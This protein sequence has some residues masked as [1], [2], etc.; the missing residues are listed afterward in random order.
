MA[1]K[2]FLSY[3]REDAAG[4]ALA[5]FD[6]LEQSFPAESLFMDVEG[7]IGRGRTLCGSLRSRSALVM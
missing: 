5:L 6:R 2:I 1:G 4:F 7:R 3:R